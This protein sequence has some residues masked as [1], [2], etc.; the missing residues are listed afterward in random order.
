VEVTGFAFASAPGVVVGHNERIAWGVTNTGPDVQDLYIEKRNP[1][2][3]YQFEYQGKWEDAQV[4]NSPIKVKGQADVPFELVVTRHGPIVSEVLGSQGNR[5]QEALALK[6]TAHAPT[7]EL[8]AIL[9]LDRAANWQEFRDGLRDFLVPTQTENSLINFKDLLRVYPHFQKFV[10]DLHL[11][12]DYEER[13]MRK[14]GNRF[15]GSGY[16][17]LNFVADVPI[18]LDAYLPPPDKDPR[19]RKGRIALALCE[20]Q[21]CDEAQAAL[22][23]QGENSHERYKSRQREVVL[24]RLSRGLVVP[25]YDVENLQASSSLPGDDVRVIE[26]RHDRGAECRGRSRHGFHREASARGLRPARSLVPA[27]CSIVHWR[28][29]LSGRQRTNA[30]PCRKRSPVT[31]S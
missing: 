4:I 26:R 10:K 30:V 13:E 1:N 16:K 31:W 18:R 15:S 9:K 17:I 6:W 23:E 2:N 3:P 12:E 8:Q 27:I 19:P 14:P 7:T 21:I 22:N 24:K 25:K 5:P 28:G 29:D 20:F 11:D